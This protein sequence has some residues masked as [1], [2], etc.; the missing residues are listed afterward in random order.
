MSEQ[1][2]WD[3][4][5]E[6]QRRFCEVYCENGGNAHDAARQAGYAKPSPEGTRML[7]NAKI[8][9]ALECLRLETTSRAIATREER[10]SW[11]TSI[12]RGD[13]DPQPEIKDRIRASEL[14]AKSQGDFLDKS[15]ISG[16]MEAL[17]LIDYRR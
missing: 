9:K 1:R 7:Q 8:I 11:W 6:K 13:G 15:H 16:D 3:G 14:L 2:W 17:P 4:L 10:Q 5:T 12:M